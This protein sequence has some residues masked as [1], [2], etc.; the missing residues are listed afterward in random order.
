GWRPPRHVARGRGEQAG[1]VHRIGYL[2]APARGGARLRGPIGSGRVDSGADLASDQVEDLEHLAEVVAAEIDG[3]VTKA[4]LL[5]RGELVH[6][7]LRALGQELVAERE[8]NRQLDR[9][10]RAPCLVCRGAEAA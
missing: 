6:H 5:V 9:L 7:G 3:D 2:S 10:E 1:K 8:A 4:E